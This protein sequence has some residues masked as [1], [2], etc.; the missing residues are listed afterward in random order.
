M[1]RVLITCV[2]QC[3]GICAL[4]QLFPGPHPERNPISGHD[5][6]GGL[7]F[8][9]RGADYRSHFR[10]RSMFFGKRLHIAQGLSLVTASQLG[11]SDQFKPWNR[12]TQN[13]DSCQGLMEISRQTGQGS[14]LS[15]STPCLL[16]ESRGPRL[17]RYGW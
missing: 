5:L 6:S 10:R 2:F 16:S 4:T 13:P 17:L 9:L 15:W 8:G 1:I 12:E 7:L 3:L 14:A 11:S